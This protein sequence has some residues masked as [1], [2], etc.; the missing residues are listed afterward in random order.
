MSAKSHGNDEDN[1]DGGKGRCAVIFTSM[2]GGLSFDSGETAK[3][4]K[5]LQLKRCT[6]QKGNS[7]KA[8]SA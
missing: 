2:G 4:P 7:N 1:A 8:F 5:T 3:K 6:L